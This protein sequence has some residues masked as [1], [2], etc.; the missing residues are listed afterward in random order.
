MRAVCSLPPLVKR[1][2]SQEASATPGRYSAVQSRASEAV[3]PDTR[4]S[5]QLARNRPRNTGGNV[6]P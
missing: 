1:L 2:R 3:Q 6:R 5:S 4:N